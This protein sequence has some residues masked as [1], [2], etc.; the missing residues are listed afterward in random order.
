VGLAALAVLVALFVVTGAWAYDPGSATL[1]LNNLS[2]SAPKDDGLGLPLSVYR[3][4]EVTLNGG[5]R[6]VSA[7]GLS[8]RMNLQADNKGT[9]EGVFYF[10]QGNL[11]RF[12]ASPLGL[13]S[14]SSRA[15]ALGITGASG[16]AGGGSPLSGAAPLIQQKMSYRV[17]TLNMTGSYTRVGD[18]F[19]FAQFTSQEL[20]D[21][22][23][24]KS[25]HGMTE[26]ALG[27]EWSASSR[28]GLKSSYNRTINEQAGSSS[29]GLT[30]TTQSNELTMKLG[31]RSSLTA[32]YSSTVD[33]WNARRAN[34]RN[35]TVN[36]GVRLAHGFGQK[37]SVTVE[38]A[39]T[40]VQQA[41]G[42][43]DSDMTKVHL[44]FK[45]VARLGLTGDFSRRQDS[46]G[47][48]ARQSKLSLATQLSSRTSIAALY[49]A[50][51]SKDSDRATT[52][53]TLDQGLG[54]A[55]LPMKLKGEYALKR[56][57]EDRGAEWKM[58]L[59]LSRPTRKIT[60]FAEMSSKPSTEYGHE[61]AMRLQLAG[62]PSAALLWTI[63]Q[64]W[65]GRGT[66]LERSELNLR[67]E[68]QMS[69]P[70]RVGAEYW[71]LRPE[72]GAGADA[73]MVV[74]RWACAKP[75]SDW[76][77]KSGDESLFSSAGSDF[78]SITRAFRE[79]P[80]FAKSGP[81]GLPQWARQGN[82]GLTLSYQ[83]F[84]PD[85]AEAVV[86]QSLSYEQ[87]L[88]KSAYTRLVYQANPCREGR[89]QF[90]TRQNMMVEV[91]AKVSPKLQVLA[92]YTTEGN[93]NPSL[94]ST[95][96]RGHLLAVR[97][98]LS[99][100]EQMEAGVAYDRIGA[101]SG[102]SSRITASVEYSRTLTETDFVS[103]KTSMELNSDPAAADH[104]CL[105]T[106]V[107]YHKGF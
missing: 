79:R 21:L 18:E 72:T 62:N 76:A 85:A 74:L 82:G 23:A 57:G 19:P 107:G 60:A 14:G 27:L 38:R 51:Q 67:L 7:F 4:A 36:R 64:Q 45:D 8:H 73:A 87:M 9:W 44:D 25:K 17:G 13:A 46:D 97:G 83:I 98:R 56:T 69:K 78:F 65:A 81:K 16:L 26:Q 84:S 96:T 86:S 66:P 99:A 12:G 88:G 33:Q 101:P 103:L 70:L 41:G 20:G 71:Q 37:S 50:S 90:D 39:L 104:T 34:Q 53:F 102:E 58:R 49:D 47:A 52:R 91:G 48:W 15:T 31:G 1:G 77:A 30:K 93:L 100:E 29:L 10:G 63:D 75:L 89:N 5:S 68:R 32:N 59:D 3:P 92:R 6:G 94:A 11:G 55:A 40:T 43:K 54:G 24:L 61:G 80:G 22:A 42:A 2:F 95:F 105:K 106:Y 35:E 28:L